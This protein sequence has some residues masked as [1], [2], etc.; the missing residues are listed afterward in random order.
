MANLESQA[1]GERGY[2]DIRGQLLI[3]GEF[4][5]LNRQKII[6]KGEEKNVR[7]S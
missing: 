5:T 3:L 1:A 6:K 4:T 2:S 7:K